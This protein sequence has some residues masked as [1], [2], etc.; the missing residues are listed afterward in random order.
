MTAAI[1]LAA[2]RGSRMGGPK[3]ALRLS[4]SSFLE[5]I[6]RTAAAARIEV[7]RVVVAPSSIPQGL[8]G[9]RLVVNPAPERGMLSSVHCGIAALPAGVSGFLLWP[10]DHPM[11][12]PETIL[13]LREAA[14]R[15]GAPVVVPTH[16]GRRGHPAW[17]SAR[18]IPEILV[19]PERVGVK[20]VVLAHTDR[21][22][23]PV[24]DPGVIGDVDTPDDYARLPGKSRRSPW[25]VR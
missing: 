1:V 17:F 8:A 16:D 11:V 13:A 14:E 3:H 21:L 20:A 6:L 9:D 2:G 19:A 15:I 25:E 24:D 23:L 7:V 12:T 4:G 22:E 5:A 10:V 18:V